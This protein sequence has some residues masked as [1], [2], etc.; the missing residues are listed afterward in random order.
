MFRKALSI[1]ISIFKFYCFT[2]CIKNISFTSVV[3]ENI[4]YFVVTFVEL[5]FSDYVTTI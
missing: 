4:E 2:N 3:F 1:R 5:P